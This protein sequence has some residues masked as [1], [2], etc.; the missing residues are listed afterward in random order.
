MSTPVVI[1]EVPLLQRK[2]EDMLCLCIKKNV[3][4]F[5]IHLNFQPVTIVNLPTTANVS[6]SATSETLI[7]T[8]KFAPAGLYTCTLD[9]YAP[10]RAEGNPFI[11][12]N[13]PSAGTKH[14]K[15][16]FQNLYVY[17]WHSRNFHVSNLT[18]LSAKNTCNIHIFWV[19]HKFAK[20]QTTLE[21]NLILV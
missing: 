15:C 1:S 10:T 17:T 18:H 6:E 4:F 2:L 12:Q 11:I 14:F 21:S 20:K 8:L 13:T 7:H 16:D 19:V 5:K 9:S 3:L